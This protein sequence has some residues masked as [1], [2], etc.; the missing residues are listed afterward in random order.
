M[1]RPPGAPTT[2]TR[3]LDLMM[4]YGSIAFASEF[5][6]GVARSAIG[7]M[8]GAFA[9]LDDSPARRFIALLVPFMIERA[10]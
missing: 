5:A 10:A 1:T 9:G 3:V 8:D 2:S 6:T 4:T 7:A